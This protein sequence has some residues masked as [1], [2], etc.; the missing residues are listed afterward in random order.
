MRLE[1]SGRAIMAV[2]LRCSV[3][4]FV[5]K[6]NGKTKGVWVLLQEAQRAKAVAVYVAL[7]IGALQQ[8][9]CP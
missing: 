4:G 7:F 5:E 6:E 8:Q 1:L 2:D 9:E 3:A